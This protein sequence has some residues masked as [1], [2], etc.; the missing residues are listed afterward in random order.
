MN[1]GWIPILSGHEV[2]TELSL[3]P[4][5]ISSIIL[6]MGDLE[7][8]K[9]I[10]LEFASNTGLES[11]AVTPRRYLW[12]DGFAVCNF[13]ELYSQTKEVKFLDLALALADQV[14]H[15]LGKHR[16]DDLQKRRGWI[17]GLSE[18][19]GKLHPT[20]GGLHIGKKLPE[21]LAVEPFDDDAEW[22]KDGQ[23]Y[24]YLTKWMQAL[25]KLH[26]VTTGQKYLKFGAEL[27]G[28]IHNKFTY[29]SGN[30][31]RM[32]W[33]M[34]IDLSRPLVPSMGHH[35]PLDGFITYYQLDTQLQ[36]DS[37]SSLKQGMEDLKSIMQMQDFSTT[38]PLGLGGILSDVFRVLQLYLNTND[39]YLLSL[40]K[41]LL[42]ASLTGLKGYNRRKLDMPAEYRLAFREFGLSIGLQAAVHMKDLFSDYH[43]QFKNSEELEQLM[44]DVLKYLPL[45]ESIHKFWGEEKNRKTATWKGHLD[46][47]M[48]M[49]ATSLTS[50]GFLKIL[51]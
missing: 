19:E 13:L 10:M 48:V 11:A 1:H 36:L 25:S 16:V 3:P 45:R 50:G 32:F 7:L 5:R 17:S 42:K 21:R 28:G 37:P 40:F 30:R 43:D 6:R 41:D 20:Q 8:S 49:W 33:K 24:H 9:G 51:P 44:G 31:K 22:D 4:G 2:E 39:Q 47:N 35:D 18:E 34:S 46:I 27:V 12:T 14:H 38:D 15:T 29:Q 26:T 23:Y